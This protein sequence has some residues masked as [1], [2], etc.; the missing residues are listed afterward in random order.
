MSTNGHVPPQN[1]EAEES[2]LGAMMLAPNA[3][4][5]VAEEVQPDDFYRP[6]HGR[7]F[8]AALDLHSRS[9]PVD[10]LTLIDELEKRGQLEDAGGRPR[11]HALAQSVPAAGNAG[12]YARIVAEHAGLRRLIRA[13]EAISSLGWKR[14]GEYDELLDQAEKALSLASSSSQTTDFRSTADSI[15]DIADQIEAAH[16]A[17]ETRFGLRTGF[18]DL[19]KMLTGL[20]PDTLTVIAARPSMGK[21]AL[22]LNFCENVA[23]AGTPAGMVSLEMSEPELNI[24]QLSRACRID[25]QALRTAK[26]TPEEY[27]RFKQGRL[28]LKQRTQLYIDDSAAVTAGNL[29]ASARRLHRQHGL[30]LLVVDYLQLLVSSSTEDNRQ[31]EIAQISRSLK[32]LSKELHI[33][34]VAL[35]QLNRNVESREDK[36]PRLSDLR[37]S[38]AIEQDADTVLFLY[39]DDYYNPDSDAQGIAEVIV[40]KNRMGPSGTVKLAFTGRHSTFKNLAQGVT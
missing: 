1:L 28:K 11:I 32:L 3:I 36:R 21:S 19:D 33:P 40:A 26:L 17:G 20:H 10:A 5:A 35:S 25:S 6:A 16:L 4:E 34:I 39:R 18:L 2:V 37:D 23:D 15:G 31:Q 8:T 24:R 12:H 27:E 14:P 38:G 22:G 29:R 13:G 7:I 30:G 9:E